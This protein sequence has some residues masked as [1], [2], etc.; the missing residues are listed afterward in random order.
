MPLT[1]TNV[2]AS[3]RNIRTALAFTAGDRGLNIMP[4][5][6]IHGLIAGILAPLSA[7]SQVCC[8]PGFNA[9]R[10]FALLDADSFWMSV[11]A[12]TVGLLFHGAMYGPQAAWFAEQFPIG[13]RYSGVSLGYQ[14][15]TVLSG[16][17]TPIIA[18]ALLALGGGQPWLICAYLTLLVVLSIIAAVA[19][20][21]PARD[22]SAP[23]TF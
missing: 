15:G 1:Q 10:F 7:G 20:K 2:C 17:L 6:H 13:V 4:L 12:I 3:A 19:A 11:F 5:F 21:D 22:Q 18:A 16:G 23:D 9:L 8:T 14:L